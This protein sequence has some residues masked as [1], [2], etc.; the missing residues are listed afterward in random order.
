MLTHVPLSY[1]YV[2]VYGK[3]RHMGFSMKIEFDV[4]LISSTITCVQVSDRSRA[5]LWSY[6]LQY[7][8]CDHA[9][10]PIIKKLQSKGVAIYAYG[11]YVPREVKAWVR[12]SKQKNFSVV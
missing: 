12:L 1:T 4:Y 8:V 3:T 6:E 7:F 2:T 10:P 9:T 11:V 5:S